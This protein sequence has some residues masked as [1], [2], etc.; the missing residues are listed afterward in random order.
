MQP[1]RASPATSVQ[2]LPAFCDPISG[3]GQS[4]LANR[5]SLLTLPQI[6]SALGYL[7]Q[8]SRG[9]VLRPA[10][11]YFGTK[12]KPRLFPCRLTPGTLPCGPCT[13]TNAFDSTTVHP[14]R[15]FCFRKMSPSL[16]T[17]P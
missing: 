9:H 5:P 17:Q 11:S 16:P 15:E 6:P 13:N 14:A 10:L 3:K 1:Q 7:Q 12:L 8:P 2:P 4:H